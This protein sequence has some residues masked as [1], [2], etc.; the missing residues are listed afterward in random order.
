MKGLA[1]RLVNLKRQEESI[2]TRFLKEY[3]KALLEVGKESSQPIPSDYFRPSSLAGCQRM[4]YYM[5]KGAEQD[6]EKIDDVWAYNMVGILESGTDRHERIQRVIQEMD[7]TGSLKML[8][9]EKVVK[10]IRK[11]GVKT[12]FVKW[13]EDKTE[14][15]CKNE[16]LRIYFQP[17][18]V[19]EFEG[20]RMLLEIKTANIYKFNNVKKAN[21]PL[22]E[23]IIQASAY[24]M[25]L[26]IDEIMFFY[27]DRD[28]TQHHLMLYTITEEDKDYIRK[29]VAKVDKCI[30]E[31][32]LPEAEKEKCMYCSYKQKC[33]EDGE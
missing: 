11:W 5:R 19:V 10:E 27:E 22:E 30:Q 23:H 6:K 13:N 25:G 2:E 3:N 16:D 15:R 29:K 12:E 20:K 28:F 31:D 8:D 24:G 14:A 33:Q 9:I 21:A 7:K 1:K 4:L 18:G 17:D 26:D 32:E